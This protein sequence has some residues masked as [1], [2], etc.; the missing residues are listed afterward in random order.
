L[1]ESVS[2]KGVAITPRQPSHTGITTEGKD[3]PGSQRPAVANDPAKGAPEV[4]GT[5]QL[6]MALEGALLAQFGTWATA[7]ATM[8]QALGA[9][10]TSGRAKFSVIHIEQLCEI[11]SLPWNRRDLRRLFHAMDAQR[12]GQVDFTDIARVAAPEHMNADP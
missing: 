11:L 4:I 5:E 1:E 6:A 7:E 12:I 2:E 3:A 10:T 9:P 8:A